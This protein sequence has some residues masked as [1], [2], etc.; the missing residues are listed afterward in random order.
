LVANIKGL[1]IKCGTN[2]KLL[3]GPRQI[4]KIQYRRELARSSVEPE[5]EARMNIFARCFKG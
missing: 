2:K 1:G 5:D 3:G 4:G